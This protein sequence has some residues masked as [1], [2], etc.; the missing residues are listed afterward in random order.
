MAEASSSRGEKRS[1]ATMSLGSRSWDVDVSL[2]ELV[3]W[4][5]LEQFMA[6]I[7]PGAEPQSGSVQGGSVEALPPQPVRMRR[8]SSEATHF[9]GSGL[10]ERRLS[11]ESHLQRPAA[12]LMPGMWPLL[13]AQLGGAEGGAPAALGH[14]AGGML[15]PNA[16]MLAESLYSTWQQGPVGGGGL[17]TSFPLQALPMQRGVSWGAEMLPFMEAETAGLNASAGL[18]DPTAI[19]V[20]IGGAVPMGMPPPG[21]LGAPS[22]A[23]GHGDA[24]CD[25]L[26]SNAARPMHKQRFVWTGELHRRFEAAVNT[27]GVDQAKPQV[28][29]CASDTAS[30]LA[31]CERC[32]ERS[33]T[34][35]GG[36]AHRPVAASPRAAVRVTCRRVIDV[37]VLTRRAACTLLASSC[38]PRRA[39]QL[40][41]TRFAV[42]RVRRQSPS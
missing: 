5:A 42:R 41:L 19:G 33:L 25:D 11:A 32:C 1:R 28:R 2:D 34:V 22:C 17:H 9:F 36:R 14:G 35:D 30:G 15:Q 27:L 26:A 6:D 40:W 4:E 37:S 31:G 10:A 3:E 7:P 8:P 12:G 38:S 23:I 39:A 29:A 24:N 16:A 18:M 20:G 13:S 21:M